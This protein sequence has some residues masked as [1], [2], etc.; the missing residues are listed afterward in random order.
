MPGIFRM[1][2]CRIP[3]SGKGI[4][5]G[6]PLSVLIAKANRN[7]REA[8]ENILRAYES[9][10]DSSSGVFIKP[11]I[12]FPLSEKSGQIT[13][14]RIVRALIESL[15]EKYRGIHIVLGEG[16]AAGTVPQEN[17]D[18][19]GYSALA[20]EYG[21]ELLDLDRVERVSEKWKYGVLKL[22]KIVRE[23]TYINLPILKQSSAAVISGAMK[24]QKGLLLPEIKKAFHRW[25]LH[26]PIAQL[27]AVIQPDLTILDISNLFRDDILIAGDNTYE[28]DSLVVRLLGISEPGYLEARR[29]MGINPSPE[30]LG[31][32]LES[33]QIKPMQ[34]Y[35]EYRSLFRLRLW[36]NPRAC[37]MCR[38]LLQDVARYKKDEPGSSLI[39]AVKLGRLAITG[40]E[41]VYGF[42]PVVRP[43]YKKVICIGDCTKKLAKE[44]GYAHV[45][46]CP[47]QR[48]D[49]IDLL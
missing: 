27:D 16:T 25:G 47:P 15:R 7:L 3:S 13:R 41:L 8:M 23:K 37:S 21:L 20:R 29:N 40:A 17:F 46:G 42:D 49:F 33:L 24:N 28:I 35:G 10:I 19:S 31:E 48:R 45:P 36:S 34:E 5:I 22:P 9:R 32:K 39:S 2:C 30:I 12:V 26:E 4:G 43:E 38:F 11:N 14:H 1:A 18:I 44:G 6:N